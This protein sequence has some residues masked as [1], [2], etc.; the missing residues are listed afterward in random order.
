M[1]CRRVEEGKG[2][3][4]HAIEPPHAFLVIRLREAVERA[5]EAR[6]GVEDLGL[7]AHFGEVERVLEDFR[8]HSR[9]LACSYE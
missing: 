9:D 8:G 2:E 4:T 7:Q 3:G 5:A 6:G 1:R